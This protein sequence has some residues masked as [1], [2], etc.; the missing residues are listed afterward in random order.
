MTQAHALDVGLQGDRFAG[1]AKVNDSSGWRVSGEPK[2]PCYTTGINHPDNAAFKGR[3]EEWL[4]K[5]AAPEGSTLAGAARTDDPP[6]VPMSG[7]AEP[8][9]AAKPLS[10]E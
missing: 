9:G 1:M 4:A 3:F 7:G 2:L 8:A 6:A 5:F 10:H